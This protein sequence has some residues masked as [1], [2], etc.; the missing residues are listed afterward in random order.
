MTTSDWILDIALLLVVLRQVRENPID[1]RFWLL[2]TAIIT[3]VAQKYLHGIPTAGNDLILVAVFVAT[4]AT[5]GILGGLTTRVRFD[6]TR[7][8]VKAGWTAAT[9]WVLGMG[10]RMAFYIWSTYGGGAAAIGRF[11][12]HHDITS[13]QA[14]VTAFVLMAFTEVGTRLVTIMLRAAHV[15]QQSATVPGAVQPAAFQ[16]A[17]G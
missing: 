12:I 5:L 13:S 3:V 2:P 14:W 8:L 7:V 11:S 4:G 15:R 9:L 1:R 10:S 16:A 6:G 17:L